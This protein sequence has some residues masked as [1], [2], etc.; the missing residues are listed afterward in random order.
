[1]P[2]P[3]TVRVKISSEA[4]G[5][6]ALTAVVVRDIPIRELI[7]MALVSVGRDA[8]RI[9]DTLKRGTLL[10]GASRLRWTGWDAASDDV[11][12]LLA[13]FP[14][15]DPSRAFDPPHCILAVLRGPSCHIEITREAGAAR[16]LFRRAAFWDCLLELSSASKPVYSE[17]SYLYKADRY[18]VAASPKV[19]AA[20][21]QKADLLKYSGL[22][23]QVLRSEFDRIDFYVA[24]A[25]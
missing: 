20:L 15:S 10:S 16:R 13:V 19:S 21:K 1:M 14:A 17:Y 8:A 25:S 7:E 4:A 23:A 9:R 6:I 24:R 2:L 12:R 3:E 18:S 5:T 11:E 22:E